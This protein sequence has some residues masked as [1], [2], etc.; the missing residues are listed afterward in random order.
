MDYQLCKNQHKH[1]TKFWTN[2]KHLT[3]NPLDDQ[4][5]HL[6]HKASPQN[7]LRIIQNGVKSIIKIIHLQLN[8]MLISNAYARSLLLKQQQA[9]MIRFMYFSHVIAY[10]NSPTTSKFY[11]RFQQTFRM[12]LTRLTEPSA[13]HLLPITAS[14]F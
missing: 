9:G 3:W 1:K 7:A 2:S 12:F 6:S 14:S 13:I 5:E 10:L 8:F 4:N 11:P